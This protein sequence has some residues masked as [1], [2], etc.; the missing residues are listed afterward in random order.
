MFGRYRA[1]TAVGIMNFCA[2]F[3][4]AI[5]EPLMGWGIDYTESTTFVFALLTIICVLAA[6]SILPVKR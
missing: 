4:A 3:F 5:G 1:A 2:Y 6:L